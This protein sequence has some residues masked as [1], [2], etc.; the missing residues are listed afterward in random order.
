MASGVP[1]GKQ[2][3]G[4]KKWLLQGHVT[5]R[6]GPHERE[7]QHHQQPWYKVMCLTGVDYFSTLGYQPSIA[8]QVQMS[9]A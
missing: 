2:I 9:P 1:P 6:E 8:V 7:H 4:L 3:S 5:E